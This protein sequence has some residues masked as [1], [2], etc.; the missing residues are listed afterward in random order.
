MSNQLIVIYDNMNV[1]Q[2]IEI[3]RCFWCGRPDTYNCL[4]ELD[5]NSDFDG[6][7]DDEREHECDWKYERTCIIGDFSDEFGFN[8][9][10][11]SVGPIYTADWEKLLWRQFKQPLQSENTYININWNMF[12]INQYSINIGNNNNMFISQRY[13][14]IYTNLVTLASNS[15]DS[16]NDIN[17]PYYYV[18]KC[19]YFTFLRWL[20]L[21]PHLGFLASQE[22]LTKFNA[23]LC[24]IYY[25]AI[26]LLEEIYEYGRVYPGF[27]CIHNP[28]ENIIGEAYCHN[29]CIN[30]IIDFI[31]V[32][33][34]ILILQKWMRSRIYKI[35]MIRRVYA[36]NALRNNNMKYN[37][38]FDCIQQI[39]LS[40]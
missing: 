7:R 10:D 38:N 13:I 18:N 34:S 20:I 4:C 3:K 8:V 2:Y 24:Q 22:D 26:L 11:Y 14:A 21:S 28:Y 27:S 31:K 16:D 23:N 6:I 12:N 40:C 5:Y 30:S 37:I 29:Q 19:R 33:E 32:C 9:R 1:N 35:K 25:K 36:F 17:D 15:L 39:L